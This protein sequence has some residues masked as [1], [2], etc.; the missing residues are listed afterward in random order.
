[1]IDIND[2][3][4]YMYFISSIYDLEYD[5]IRDF[6]INNDELEFN[7]GENKSYSVNKSFI[8]DSINSINSVE[9]KNKSANRIAYVIQADRFNYFLSTY[10]LEFILLKKFVL[11]LN[12]LGYGVDIVTDGDISRVLPDEIKGMDISISF[13]PTNNKNSS[14]GSNLTN[15]INHH[16]RN[17]MY[18]VMKFIAC[19]DV[20]IKCLNEASI[21]IDKKM[22]FIH[23]QFITNYPNNTSLC[24]NRVSTFKILDALNDVNFD[25]CVTDEDV[26]SQIS[27]IYKTKNIKLISEYGYS[28]ADINPHAYMENVDSNKNKLLIKFSNYNDLDIAINVCKPLSYQ[29]TVMISDDVN[30]YDIIDYMKTKDYDNFI[31]INEKY[32]NLLRDYNIMIDFNSYEE[33]IE[34]PNIITIY[35]KSDIIN[36]IETQNIKCIDKANIVS[37]IKIILLSQTTMV[38]TL[39][40]RS[41]T[42]TQSLTEEQKNEI[43][44][45][46]R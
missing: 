21:P 26:Y 30:E 37:I 43:K 45:I 14:V 25:I 2:K 32:F 11:M 7:Y 33:C 34:N 27:S 5:K 9:L 10:Y 3:Q 24:E 46:F 17:R 38:K 42:P 1:M 44:K 8:L 40:Q 22:A 39:S 28:Q 35:H 18:S 23:S 12:N 41:F 16:N 31:V 29:M 15:S 19:N 13:S 36:P 20:S 6:K 4:Y